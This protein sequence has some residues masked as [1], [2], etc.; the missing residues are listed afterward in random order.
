MSERRK[1]KHMPASGPLHLIAPVACNSFPRGYS[2][3]AHFIQVS[4]QVWPLQKDH[5]WQPYVKQNPCLL[6]YSLSPFFVFCLC[7]ALSTTW[8]YVICFI[9]GLLFICPCYNLQCL[10]KQMACILYYINKWVKNWTALYILIGY[11]SCLT[12]YCSLPCP[13]IFPHT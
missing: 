10:E 6:H 3:L 5:S 9:I 1:T 8:H 7:K 12:M 11:V 4:I 13:C 2:L